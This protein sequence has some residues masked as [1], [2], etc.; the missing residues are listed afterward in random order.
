M[1]VFTLIFVASFIVALREVLSG[2]RDGVLIFI[3]LGLSMYTTAMSVTYTLG[4]KLFVPVF[5]YFKEILIPVSYT[6]LTRPTKRIV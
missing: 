2:R 3:I 1:F 4:L 5:Q 6:H